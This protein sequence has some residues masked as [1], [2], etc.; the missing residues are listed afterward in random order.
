MASF[1]VY[2]TPLKDSIRTS[3]EDEWVLTN[4]TPEVENASTKKPT[5]DVFRLS[6]QLDEVATSSSTE[7]TRIIDGEDIPCKIDLFF[8]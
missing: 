1:V 6:L 3:L 2:E 4:L 7:S 8:I 5:T